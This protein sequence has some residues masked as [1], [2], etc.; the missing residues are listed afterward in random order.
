MPFTPTAFP[1]AGGGE[2]A[3]QVPCVEEAGDDR[4]DHDGADG[5]ETGGLGFGDDEIDVA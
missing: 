1:G 5:V 3:F 4:V 2:T